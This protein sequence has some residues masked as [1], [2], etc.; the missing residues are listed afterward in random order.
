MRYSPVCETNW[1]RVT[2]QGAYY[3]GGSIR[4]LRGALPYEGLVGYQGHRGQSY[5]SPMVYAPGS[6]CVFIEGEIYLQSTGGPV[7]VGDRKIC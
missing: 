7:P 6:T 5:W 3:I 4:S 2:G 1:V